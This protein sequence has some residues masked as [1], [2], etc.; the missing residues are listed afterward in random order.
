[1]QTYP[2][3]PTPHPETAAILRAAREPV[4]A[5]WK[6]FVSKAQPTDSPRSNAFLADLA[7]GNNLLSCLLESLEVGNLTASLLDAVVRRVQE[8]E[9][10]IADFLTEK[11]CLLS[12]ILGQIPDMPN[13]A[14]VMRQV[15]RHL[16]Q[17]AGRVLEKTAQV[18]E[19]VVKHGGRA[20]CH[21]DPQGR[22]VYANAQM[23]RLTG[24]KTLEGILFDALFIPGDQGFIHHALS[25]EKDTIPR[26]RA[27][28][29]I[30]SP[31]DRPVPV[32]AELAP[33]VISGRYLGGYAGLVDL[34]GPMA[35][36]YQVFDQVPVGVIKI[37]THRVL[38]YAN[39]YIRRVLGTDKTIIGQSVEDFFPDPENRKILN[40]EVHKRFENGHTGA[41]PIEMT[42][43]DNHRK[44]PVM[45]A[46]TPER[47]PQGKII[48]SMAIIRSM[49]LDKAAERINRHIV[50]CVDATDLLKKVLADIAD[51]CP[52][53]MASVAVYSR[54]L[55]H[56]RALFTCPEMQKT[57]RW[58]PLP[59]S[60]IQWIRNRE[61]DTI[62]DLEAFV[63]LPEWH[64]LKQDKYVQ[65]FLKENLHSVIRFPVFDSQTGEAPRL[66]AAISFFRKNKGAFTREDQE[67]LAA[68]PMEKAVQAA[69]HMEEKKGLTFRFTLVK[70]IFD[71]CHDMTA[72]AHLITSELVDFYQWQTVSIFSIDERD[73]VFR[74]LSQAVNRNDAVW[75]LPPDY[76]QGVDQGVM[77]H[78]RQTGRPVISGD[79]TADP[80]FRDCLVNP[81]QKDIRSVLCL[82][83]T[84]AGR[85]FWLL[86]IVDP[87][88]NTFSKD[89]LDA[90][91]TVH[92]EIGTL[93]EHA[94]QHH[95]LK[96]TLDNVSDA[97]LV[98]DSVKGIRQCNP[99]V[100]K[101]LGYEAS[102]I[103]QA[104]VESLFMDPEVPAWLR[105]GGQ[106]PGRETVLRHK[107]GDPVTVYLSVLELPREIGGHLAIA[108]DLSLAKRM[109]ELDYLGRLYYE[110][111]V[112]TKTPLSLL[113]SW[114]KHVQEEPDPDIRRDTLSKCLT[115]VRR[116]RLTYDRLVL[117]DAKAGLVPYQPVLLDIAEILAR[118]ADAF[119]TAEWRKVIIE[120]PARLPLLEGD[121]FQ[122][123]F[124]V[125]TILS[126]LLRTA[127]L[128]GQVFVQAA[129]TQGD[130]ML[131]LRGTVP[132]PVKEPGDL[133]LETRAQ[134]SETIADMALG[135]P[136][137]RS[138]V[139]GHKGE[140]TVVRQGEEQ[141]FT[142][143]LPVSPEGGG[144]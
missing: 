136:V 44:I 52:F 139:A 95:F 7:S 72:V 110:I 45:I 128:E 2:D 21:I 37:D 143:T 32:G 54:D 34:S 9:R 26:M 82:P 56:T 113:F 77:G 137:I 48:G 78:V 11:S 87:L 142:L 102:D 135:E 90:L 116:L 141:V 123:T 50:A 31:G 39:T 57:I 55:G 79:V 20:F 69:L 80:E 43:L 106:I 140:Y 98:F 93:L 127:G 42:R 114:L 14:H 66:V 104:P 117:Y 53:D 99:A 132:L 119:P 70:K 1:L 73:R 49:E 108:R 6:D 122:L 92:G 100:K 3:T 107:N 19:K 144:L 85:P 97:I 41:Y 62:D 10:S 96:Q 118:L 138:F 125:E 38:T 88:K 22:I 89:E 103:E 59:P 84:A 121:L 33:L 63:N 18:Y 111:A 91:R 94:F 129:E 35:G 51:I 124:C 133:E 130:I 115:Q 17:V 23:Y 5:A 47:D 120:K 67:R 12:A 64:E 8:P 86:I 58:W 131:S 29:L 105:K 81:Y 76:T 112:Q 101:L 36:I 30:L 4:V 126:Y 83:I 25:P 28:Q 68:L 16:D 46:A 134:L 40:R 61:R 109:E 75:R 60:L 65:E 71:T 27:L 74:L 13:A 15:C 24:R